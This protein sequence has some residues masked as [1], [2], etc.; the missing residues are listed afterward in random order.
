[1]KTRGN[2]SWLWKSDLKAQATNFG[3]GNSLLCHNKTDTT[4]A[5][6][7]IYLAHLID[8]TTI[9]NWIVEN[10]QKIE[11]I[12]PRLAN[13]FKKTV[14]NLNFREIRNAK[15]LAIGPRLWSSITPVTLTVP[16]QSPLLSTYS[17]LYL[18]AIWKERE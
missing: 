9:C 10:E 4:Y 17:F 16:V 12:W 1:M 2:H 8:A 3:D 6:F 5:I 14:D 11:N 18:K 13:F 7:M 15:D